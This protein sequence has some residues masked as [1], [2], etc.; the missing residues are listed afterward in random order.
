MAS[1]AQHLMESS[2]E[3]YLRRRI[4]E[5]HGICLKFTSPGLSGMPDRI[6]VY[7][8]AVLFVEL[9]R[10]GGKP[11]PQQKFVAD[12]LRRAGALVYCVSTKDEVDS[13]LA[14]MGDHLY[15]D[16]SNYDPI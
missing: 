4:T 6:I 12:W 14:E 9:K 5:K 11:R 8:G 15:P 10:P 13:F 7:K 3:D 1:K 16:P 2:V